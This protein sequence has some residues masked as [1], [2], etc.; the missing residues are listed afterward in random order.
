MSN[1]FSEHSFATPWWSIHQYTTRWINPYLLVELHVG[2]R[3]LDGLSHLLLLDVHA[4]DVGVG[5]VRLLIW[6]ESD[7]LIEMFKAEEK[8]RQL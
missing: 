1:S 8:G 6:K 4:S 3:Q 5:H 2:Q 7:P